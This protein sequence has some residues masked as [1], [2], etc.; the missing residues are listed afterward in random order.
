MEKIKLP[1]D[2]KILLVHLSKSTKKLD[3]IIH[4]VMNAIDTNDSN[5]QDRSF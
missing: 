4:T 3:E 2:D 5:D 1:E